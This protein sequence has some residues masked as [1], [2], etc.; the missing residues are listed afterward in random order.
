MFSIGAARFQVDRWCR[1]NNHYAMIE[2][3]VVNASTSQQ[4]SVF[5]RRVVAAGE[6]DKLAPATASDLAA[7]ANDDHM[8]SANALKSTKRVS[9]SRDFLT[10]ADRKAGAF[11]PVDLHL[12]GYHN[13]Q[14][15]HATKEFSQGGAV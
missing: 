7:I 5:V 1:Q 6:C 4:A 11:L 8:T 14:L 13:F 9:D 12:W 3:F 10:S 2:N 15:Q